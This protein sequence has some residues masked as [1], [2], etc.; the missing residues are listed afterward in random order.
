MSSA[1]ID[2]VDAFTITIR[3]LLKRAGEFKPNG[4]IEPA[5]TAQDLGEGIKEVEQH[6]PESRNRK[7]AAIETACRN[8]FYDLVVRAATAKENRS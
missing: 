8:K 6:S 4:G 3:K 5:L 1:G 2:F 7:Y